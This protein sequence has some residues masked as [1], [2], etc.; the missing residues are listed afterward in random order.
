[1]ERMEQEG[2]VGQPNHAGKREILVE[3]AQDE[4]F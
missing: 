3:G 1:M 2:I 4:A